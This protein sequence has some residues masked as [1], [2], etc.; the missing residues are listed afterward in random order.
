MLGAGVVALAATGAARADDAGARP[1]P[2]GAFEGVPPEWTDVLNGYVHDPVTYGPRLIAIEREAGASLPPMFRIAAGDALLRAGNR[3][4]AERVFE[5]SLASGEG[6]PW[7]DFASL[8]LGTIRLASGDEAG[9]EIYFGRLAEADEASSRALGHLGLGAT[10][11]ASGRFAEAQAAFDATGDAADPEIQHAGKL[12]S[13]LALHGSGDHERAAAAFDA[14]AAAD[15][16]GPLGQDARYAA[17][18]ARLAMGEREESAAALRELVR[19]CDATRSGRRTA[20]ALRNLDARAMG[21]DWLR[22]YRRTG[23]G[24]LRAGGKPMFSIEGCALAR[25]TLRAIAQNDARLASTR[26][27]AAAPPRAASAARATQP[28]RPAPRSDAPHGELPSGSW[29]SSL[30]ALGAIATLV[31]LWRVVG[32]GAKAG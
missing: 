16:E 15:P 6:Y 11:A 31:V 3:R 17:A 10:Y 13:A 2:F 5:E 8:A 19:S 28:G 22:S 12:G 24:D 29:R 32:R 18:R 4:G 30:L 26:P 25:S 27:A 21:R 7:D 1:A 9:A 14:I 20:R 23:W